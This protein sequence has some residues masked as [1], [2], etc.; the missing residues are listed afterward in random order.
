MGARRSARGASGAA[1]C[2]GTNSVCS[3]GSICLHVEGR[4]AVTGRC[5]ARRLTRAPT[6]TCAVKGAAA[7]LVERDEVEVTGRRAWLGHAVN[8]DGRS[9]GLTAPNGPS[10]VRL[11]REALRRAQCS[12]DAVACL[13]AHGTGTVL[14]DP[15]EV[16]AA[17]EAW[18]RQTR[19]CRAGDGQCQDQFWAHGDRGGRVGRARALLCME[20]RPDCR[21]HLHLR[22]LNEFIGSALMDRV[23]C[24]VPVEGVTWHSETKVAGVSSFGFSGTN[25]HVMVEYGLRDALRG[26]KHGAL[27]QTW[28]EQFAIRVSA[29]SE[30]SLRRLAAEYADALERGAYGVAALSS[31]TL[32]RRHAFSNASALVYGRRASEVVPLL[33]AAALSGV[34]EGEALEGEQLAELMRL[35]SLDESS[36]NGVWD[37]TAYSFERKRFWLDAERLSSTTGASAVGRATALD[38]G[39]VVYQIERESLAKWFVLEDHLVYGVV[40]LPAAAHVAVVAEQ[41]ATAAVGAEAGRQLDQVVMRDV[42]L[43]STVVVSEGLVLQYVHERETRAFEVRSLDGASWTSHVVGKMEASSAAAARSVIVPD[44]T[45]AVDVDGTGLWDNALG[46]VKFGPSFRWLQR[47]LKG[48]GAAWCWLSAPEGWKAGSLALPVEVLDAMFQS[49]ML[50]AGGG[51]LG[52]RAMVPFAV[53][54]VAVSLWRLEQQ[55]Q[56]TLELVTRTLVTAETER[57]LTLDVDLVVRSGHA[58]VVM[59]GATL[60]DVTQH[61]GLLGQA[62]A[63][64][65][66]T[67]LLYEVGWAAD[68]GTPRVEPVVDGELLIVGR[69]ARIVQRLCREVGTLAGVR[70]V[71]SLV[72]ATDCAEGL[73]RVVPIMVNALALGARDQQSPVNLTV[74]FLQAVLGAVRQSADAR[75]TVYTL[76]AHAQ[77]VQGSSVEPW[78]RAAWRWAVCLPWSAVSVSRPCW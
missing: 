47:S 29:R 63:Q 56:Q 54:K 13:E 23:R 10:Q 49:G 19:Q 60:V 41:A 68:A 70:M 30:D 11:I 38:E 28:Q 4:H 40:V 78:S 45:A 26:H 74:T 77:R 22:Q 27:E 39:R 7:L 16:Q 50:A 6:A 75:A 53:D 2:F 1:L 32:L 24:V 18:A 20:A 5:A 69:C 51:G 34:S 15:I 44:A 43:R 17:A 57:T 46:V 37:V 58:A 12:G 67:Q 36:K 64:D 76:V 33:R 48:D 59:Q 25:A 3:R 9:N 52:A 31:A 61:E 35:A 65:S 55:E 21:S 72:W 71:E 8:Q 62:S 42:E 14:G 73:P 66:Q